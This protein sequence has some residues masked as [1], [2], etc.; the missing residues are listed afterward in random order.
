[1]PHA[2][3]AAGSVEAAGSPAAQ[4]TGGLHPCGAAPEKIM[5]KKITATTMGCAESCF[6]RPCSEQRRQQPGGCRVAAV[7]AGGSSS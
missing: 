2:G 1:M 3:E 7:A 4:S 5:M 6:L